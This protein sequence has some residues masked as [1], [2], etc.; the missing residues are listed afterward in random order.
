[1]L[2]TAALP[3][4]MASHVLNPFSVSS[5]HR[6]MQRLLS[7]TM[8]ADITQDYF[9]IGQ[10]FDEGDYYDLKSAPNGGSE[11]G[12]ENLTWKMKKG[13]LRGWW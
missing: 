5:P 13:W 2:P 7:L 4:P 1:M 6:P 9:D 8:D 10:D 3:R 11:D 12:V